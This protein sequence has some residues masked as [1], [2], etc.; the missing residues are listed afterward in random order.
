M[1]VDYNKRFARAYKMYVA[2]KNSMEGETI[3]D[4]S[5]VARAFG[6]LIYNKF[7]RTLIGISESAKTSPAE[8]L[9]EDHFN[10]CQKVG[11]Y[12][13]ESDIMSREEFG[14]LIEESKKTITVTKQENS[15]LRKY[16]KHKEYGRGMEAYEEANIV[17][18]FF[19]T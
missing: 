12:M 5:Y 19:K 10:N 7:G 6:Q 14:S 8:H 9:T 18:H 13:V 16:Q 15:H 17:V 4:M 3:D 11:E 1:S 2:L